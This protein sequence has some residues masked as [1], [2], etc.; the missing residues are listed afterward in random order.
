M[1]DS[2]QLRELNEWMEY[3][4]HSAHCEKLAQD[5]S[6]ASAKLSQLLP[7]IGLPHC[8]STSIV[9]NFTLESIPLDPE[10]V[11]ESYY[12]KLSSHSPA[13]PS[14]THNHKITQAIEFTLAMN[15]LRLDHFFHDLHKSY[16]LIVSLFNSSA[17]EEPISTENN[18]VPPQ[19]TPTPHH[20]N[21]PPNLDTNFTI[22]QFKEILEHKPPVLSTCAWAHFAIMTMRPFNKATGVIARSLDEQLLKQTQAIPLID[23]QLTISLTTVFNKHHEKYRT[24]IEQ[25]QNKTKPISNWYHFWAQCCL[26][27]LHNSI[28]LYEQ[29][30]RKA[31]IISELGFTPNSR[32]RKILNTIL[33]GT[34]QH[35]TTQNWCQLTGAS[36]AAA[37]RDIA[38]LHQAHLIHEQGAGRNTHYI[39]T[40]Q[41]NPSTHK[42]PN[43]ADET[44]SLIKL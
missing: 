2:H 28:E 4:P 6:R 30:Q 1:I 19:I 16:Q 40:N 26:E 7:P 22:N 24:T 3:I 41:L 25:C 12:Q 39:P 37:K 23:N 20:T 5:I 31:F 35:I 42:K 34:T 8:P 43:P 15:E 17:Q 44:Y 33:D 32:Q 36:I 21:L 9:A 14:P 13:E 27:A 11:F 10:Q 29:L 18:M 38:Q